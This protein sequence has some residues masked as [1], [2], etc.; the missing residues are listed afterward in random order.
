MSLT[1]KHWAVFALAEVATVGACCAV[2]S[3]VLAKRTAPPEAS[4]PAAAEVAP[5]L[6]EEETGAEEPPE[7]LRLVRAAF[8][9]LSELRLQFSTREPFVA[10]PEPHVFVS[11]GVEN[12]SAF[13]ERDSG[14]VRLRG[15]FQPETRYQV[16]VTADIETVAGNRLEEEAKVC[17]LSPKA[18]K[19]EPE[20]RFCTDGRYLPLG[21]AELPY[22]TLNLGKVS[23]AV[24]RAYENN[25]APYGFTSWDAEAAM[26]TVTNMV[27]QL[28]D[29]EDV[30]T[31]H[32]LDVGALTGGKPGVY[33][34]QAESPA[35]SWGFG[36]NASE[37]TVGLTDLAVA[38]SQRKDAFRV[39]VRRLSDRTPVEQA[40]VAVYSQKNQ[41]TH[42]GTTD[43]LGIAALAPTGEGA[44]DGLDFKAIAVRHGEDF[45][46]VP[47]SAAQHA[48]SD[49]EAAV[50]TDVD[51]VRAMI[52]PD[53]EA[54]RPGESVRVYAM[55]RTAALEPMADLP[56]TLLLHDHYG[57]EIEKKAV[58]SDAEGVVWVDFSIDKAAK[59]GM[60]YAIVRF[61]D[62]G[63]DVADCGFYVADF[64]PDRMKVS[65]EV[66]PGRVGIDAKSYFGTDVSEAKG[67]VNVTAQPTSFLP[68]AWKAW[69]IGV[70]AES[71]TVLDEAVQKGEG[72]L[73]LA[74]KDETV[75]SA[76]VVYTAQVRLAEPGARAVT[77]SARSAL[78]FTAPSYVGIRQEAGKVQATL[79]VPEDSDVAEA[80]ASATLELL[81]WQPVAV[82]KYGRY[83]Y[84]WQ[85]VATPVSMP[86]ERVALE[87][88]RVLDVPLG[89]LDSGRYALTL[90]LES[91]VKTRHVFWLDAGEAGE[92]SSNPARLVFKTDKPCYLPGDT[93]VLTFQAPS[94]GVLL[95]GDGESLGT[96]P[97]EA[98][99]TVR[100]ETAIPQ[101]YTGSA[102]LLGV[103]FIPDGEVPD[104]RAFG[105]AN[106]KVD[107]A[108]A[109]GMKVS[110]TAADAVVRPLGETQLTVRLAL[111]DGT[112]C[113]GEVL[114]Y[115]V[116]ES[117]LDM[118][119]TA[120]PDPLAA[121]A[122]AVGRTIAFGD[123]YGLLFP[124]IR[125]GADGKIGGDGK[126][127]EPRSRALPDET[128]QQEDVARLLLPPLA[129]PESGEL[130]VPVTLP[131]AQVSLKCIAVAVGQN[132]FGAADSTIAVRPAV[133]LRPSG[134]RFACQ[135]DAVEMAFK[136]ENHDLPESPF[137]LSV[138]GEDIAVGMLA[139]KSVKTILHCLAPVTAENVAELRVGEEC[140]EA[141][142]PILVR[143]ALPETEVSTFA[144]LP[145][146]APVPEDAET[147]ASLKAAA[148]PA[149]DWLHNY[150]Y[151]CTEQLSAKALPYTARN[152]DAARAFVRD[153]IRHLKARQLYSG[154]FAM[155]PG[156]KTAWTEGSLFAAQIVLSQGR[157][158]ATLG[159]LRS[160]ASDLSPENRGA[161][162]HAAWLLALSGDAGA[163]IAARN[164]LFGG[165]EDVAAYVAA[166]ALV[167]SNYAGEGAPLMRSWLA[168]NGTGALPKPL[169]PGCMDGTATQA[170]V[171]ALAAQCG[172]AEAIPEAS[173]AALLTAQWR[174][175]QANAWAALA[176]ESLDQTFPGTLLRTRERRAANAPGQAIQVS[177][178][179]VDATGAPLKEL[180]HGEL[181]YLRI[182]LSL[183]RAAKNVVVCDRLPGGLEYEDAALATRESRAPPQWAKE[184]T[185]FPVDH[186]QK[187]GCTV[188][189]VGT[190]REGTQA[191]VYPVRAVARG[192]FAFPATLVEAMYDPGLTGCAFAGE[193]L[194][195]R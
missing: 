148:E 102:W 117:V 8:N 9:G 100:L 114:L 86:A 50:S 183:P 11:P 173:L 81:E 134:A 157:D 163:D 2:F 18:S 130:T 93:A 83:R 40:E 64:V 147:V 39:C 28:E 182:D 61:G 172:L 92:R 151:G 143:A 111:P 101:N 3:H 24:S 108:A 146:G 137:S 62:S 152:D 128:L 118:W 156:G 38:Y 99:G 19:P 180:A 22:E 123:N 14:V 127:F 181:A 36:W 59:S 57:K 107:Q 47:L 103:T 155:W 27:V 170:M 67:T 51:A 20:F 74:F 65:V 132:R 169:L 188:C 80:E 120:T 135:G 119:R 139:A 72:A 141:K 158:D 29:P 89:A 82:L 192:E 6:L 37:R 165:K 168:A 76:P 140:V 175:T 30:R 125:L 79:L 63:E 191:I 145:E 97:V 16:R 7:P 84:E 32:M 189:F 31:A 154:A 12:L 109:H 110:L 131:D 85:E 96:R 195:I 98:A 164:L 71:V 124:P 105:L 90:R 166:A 150:A 138:N 58:R 121:L 46:F 23:F 177:R 52:W 55:V 113:G 44:A 25:L 115:A 21:R 112:P 87:A 184:L 48:A 69:T 5:G 68:E 70:P 179:L 45:V 33:R 17:L 1:L 95:V 53:R 15:A 171:L 190:A 10:T 91:G 162:A 176:L 88:G 73:E 136:I 193:R 159:F 94:A 41:V 187:D 122:G 144:F 153:T 4:M 160:L 186:V 66:A 142:W 106:L 75:W 178:T 60:A 149:L 42:R 116:D 78:C 34:I 35:G 126:S 49:D 133:T 129:V 54:V 174:T 77:V 161:A 185:S 104:G 194:T 26:V 167:K 56:M 43:A 13:F